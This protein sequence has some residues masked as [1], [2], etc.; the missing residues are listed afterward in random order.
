MK[1]CENKLQKSSK[2][3]PN[4]HIYFMKP[5]P[6]LVCELQDFLST[7]LMERTLKVFI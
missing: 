1:D 4:C 5:I 7:D 2:P 6:S 3:F